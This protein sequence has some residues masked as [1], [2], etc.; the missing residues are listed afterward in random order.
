MKQIC[1]SCP[2][3][4]FNDKCHCLTG[5]GNPNYGKLIVVPNVDYDAY[6][7]KG[8]TFSKYVEIIEE[9]LSS[10]TGGIIDYYIV[11][12]VR[13]KL[14]D[15]CPITKKIVLNCYT[16]TYKDI[17]DN[18]FKKILLL[19]D[20]AK[21]IGVT[22]ITSELDNIY[23]SNDIHLRGYSVNYSPFIKYVDDAKYETFR[24]NL[25]KWH[26]ASKDNN[27]NGYNVIVK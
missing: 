12:L 16:H 17:I 27:Y 2:L 8:M 1:D 10:S 24:D 19:G 6:K 7:N 23:I 5:V 9:V 18:D 26:N 3:R 14:T 25:T 4:L 20:A 11:P 15:K 13:C 22:N 21:I